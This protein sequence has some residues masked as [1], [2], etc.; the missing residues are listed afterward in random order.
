MDNIKRWV[1]RSDKETSLPLFWGGKR[2]GWIYSPFE[3]RRF[4]TLETC[5][6]A[7]K[8]AHKDYPVWKHGRIP[9]EPWKIPG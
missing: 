5:E 3:A 7:L 8:R 9:P 1:I 4:D 6:A 2:K